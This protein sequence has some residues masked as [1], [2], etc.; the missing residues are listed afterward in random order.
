[1]RSGIVHRGPDDCGYLTDGDFGFGMRRLSIIDVEGGHQPIETSDARYAVVFNGEIYSHLELR[2][3]LDVAGYQFRTQSDT[4]T[5]LASYV[6]WQDEAW[7]RLE[8]MYAAAVW[9]RHARILTLVRDPLGIKPLFYTCQ[10]GGLA[11]AS[12]L[13]ALRILLDHRF[14][15]DE[16][17]VDDFF[18]FGHVQK[19]RSIFREVRSFEPGHV[20]R[21]NGTGEPQLSCFWRPEFQVRDDLTETEWVEATRERVVDTVQAHMLSDVP[22]GAFLS[23][24]VDSG[25][26]AAVMSQTADAPVKAFTLGSPA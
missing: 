10:N 11:F 13:R 9:D 22:V 8:G 26:I 5:V 21:M 18:S 2:S 24:G 23:G 19:P 16:R 25:T 12:E 17:A 6:H 3:E 7:V 4:E 14:S 20:L 15:M 1:M